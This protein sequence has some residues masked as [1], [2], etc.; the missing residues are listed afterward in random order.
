MDNIPRNIKKRAIALL[1]IGGNYSSN[2][3]RLLQRNKNLERVVV[4]VVGIKDFSTGG[5][6]VKISPTAEAAQM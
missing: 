5:G 1:N 6:G 3:T 4:Y 2:R